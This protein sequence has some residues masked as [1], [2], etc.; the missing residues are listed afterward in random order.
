[1]T[2]PHKAFSDHSRWWIFRAIWWYC[3]PPSVPGGYRVEA[4]VCFNTYEEAVAHYLS[5]AAT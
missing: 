2:A 5:K 4:A 1:V 3:I